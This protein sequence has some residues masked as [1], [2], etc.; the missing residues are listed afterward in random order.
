MDIEKILAEVDLTRKIKLLQ[1]ARGKDLPDVE[2]FKKQ[3]EIS[4][5]DINDPAIR[6]DKLVKTEDDMGKPMTKTEKVNRIPVSLQK[7]I[8]KRAASFLFGNDVKLVGEEGDA[9]V[10]AITKVLE[11]NKTKYFNKKIA[12]EIFSATEVAEY[13]YPVATETFEDYGFST[14]YKLRSTIFS[15]KNGDELYPFFDDFGDMKAFS[16]KYKIKDDD[17]KEIT[18]FETWTDK[19]YYRWRQSG[20]AA[21]EEDLPEGVDLQVGK[22]P[23]IYGRQ[24]Q[25]EWEDVQPLIDRLEKVLSNLADTNDYHASPKIFVQGVIKGWAEKG[26][27]GAIIEGEPGSSAGYMAW[28]QAPES[29]RL[30]IDTLLRL[31][32]SLSQTPD[33]SFEAV[34]G[35]GNAASGVGLEILFLDPKLKVE[36]HMEVFGEY[37]QRRVNLIKAFLKK[38]NSSL[39]TTGSIEPV[40]TPYMIDDKKDIIDNI[41]TSVTG[42]IMSKKTGI[43]LNPLV[44]NADEEFELVTKEEEAEASSAEGLNKLQN[45]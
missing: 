15:P 7:L 43:G 8:V 4:G 17:D 27:S 16:R 9:M 23:V 20:G 18:F 37:L 44:G 2:K 26:E 33:I 29:V 25:V 1:K 31:I 41:V 35:I 3:Y 39:P 30:E 34:K 13:W 28:Q 6:K 42:G 5:H 45:E 36:E 32:H 10:A 22:I 12:K 40:V 14:K 19:K 11:Q 21:W 38:M 24:D